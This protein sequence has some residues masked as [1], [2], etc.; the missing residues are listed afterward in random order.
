MLIVYI[1]TLLMLNVYMRTGIHGYLF[2]KNDVSESGSRCEVT[3]R[4]LLSRRQ[5]CLR[6]IPE[7]VAI[8]L[9]QFALQQLP[10]GSVG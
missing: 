7:P 1:Y 5:R 2:M 4:L 6:T 8:V 10:R 3:S 9:S